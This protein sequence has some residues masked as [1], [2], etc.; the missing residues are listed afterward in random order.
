MLR[1]TLNYFSD[2]PSTIADIE[3][4]LARINVGYDARADI[5]RNCVNGGS[6]V[7]NALI[8]QT[9]NLHVRMFLDNHNIAEKFA[10]VWLRNNRVVKRSNVWHR[11]KLECFRQGRDQCPRGRWRGKLRAESV[12]ICG[13]LAY[14]GDCRDCVVS[15][16][17]TN[18]ILRS[19]CGG[20]PVTIFPELMERSEDQVAP[21][22]SPDIDVPA[23]PLSRKRH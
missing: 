9:P 23:D 1:E 4:T 3:T 17:P 22:G 14:K 13:P 5:A 11:N 16:A 20:G 15:W 18:T 6:L 7:Y 10:W 19:C 21:L 2:E 8:E 12:C